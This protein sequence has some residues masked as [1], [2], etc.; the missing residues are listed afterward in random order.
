MCRQ[1]GIS[2]KLKSVRKRIKRFELEP[3]EVIQ[4]TR[5]FGLTGILTHTEIACNSHLSYMLNKQSIKIGEHIHC[6]ILEDLI[7]IENVSWV[8]IVRLLVYA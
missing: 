2:K 1:H 7:Q 3:R 8:L 5:K 4:E 6:V